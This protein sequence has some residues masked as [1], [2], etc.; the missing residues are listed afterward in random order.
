MRSWRAARTRRL[1][2]SYSP[3]DL[4]EN[5][6]HRTDDRNQIGQHMAARQ[7]F[8][9]LQ[10]REARRADLAAIGPVGAVGDEIDAEFAL[11][12]LDRRIGFAG[13]HVI[14]LGVELEVMD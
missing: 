11:W 8:G 2:W 5:D 1:R 14:A 9:R 3:V 10:H 12:C 13:R 4:A 6:V 7:E